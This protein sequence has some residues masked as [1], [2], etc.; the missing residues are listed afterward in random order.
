MKRC[1]RLIKVANQKRYQGV[2]CDAIQ[3]H[4]LHTFTVN[5][6]NRVNTHDSVN[7]TTH[8]ISNASFRFVEG[9]K[10][11]IPPRRHPIIEGYRVVHLLGGHVIPSIPP[12]FNQKEVNKYVRY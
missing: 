8:V 9:I 12:H 10:S 5:G 4:E 11:D 7:N 6:S 1:V 2:P 3:H